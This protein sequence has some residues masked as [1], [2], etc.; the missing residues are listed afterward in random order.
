MKPM[1]IIGLNVSLVV[2]DP[3]EFGTECGTGPFPGRIIDLEPTRALMQ[4]H[5]P[6]DYKGRHFVGALVACRHQDATMDQIVEM[7]EV[8][9]NIVLLAAA[10]SSLQDFEDMRP[11]DCLAVIGSLRRG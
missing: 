10:I 3:W 1:N 7:R 2:T 8:P 6:I 9:A 5:S 4:L 11:D